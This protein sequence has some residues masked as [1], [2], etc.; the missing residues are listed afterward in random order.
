[1]SRIVVASTDPSPTQVSSPVRSEP[2]PR[3][4]PVPG[5]T[6]VTA[7][8]EAAPTP[9]TVFDFEDDDVEGEIRR[10]DEELVPGGPAPAKL[11]SLIEIPENFVAQF[12]KMIED[13]M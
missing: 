4:R 12:E 10:P 6:V 5:Q 1:M 9:P 11:H 3:P 2:K 13:R 7:Q 8:A